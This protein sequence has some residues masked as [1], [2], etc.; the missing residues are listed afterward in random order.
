MGYTHPRFRW[1]HDLTRWAGGQLHGLLVR[2]LA[3][4]KGRKG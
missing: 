3:A 4:A 1:I 2:L